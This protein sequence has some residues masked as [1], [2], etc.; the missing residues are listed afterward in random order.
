MSEA[1]LYLT[2]RGRVSGQPRRIEIWFVEHAG[3]HYIVAEGRE[4]AGWVKNLKACPSVTFSVGPRAAPASV[5]PQ[6]PA[7]ARTLDRTAFPELS[8]AVAKAMDAKYDWSDGLIVELTPVDAAG[9]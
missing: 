8:A 5:V 1:F 9:D 3:K 6:T 7:R 2:T 4:Q